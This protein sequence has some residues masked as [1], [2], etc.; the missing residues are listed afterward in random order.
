MGVTAAHLLGIWLIMGYSLHQPG[1]PSAPTPI[2]VEWMTASL[3]TT[4]ISPSQQPNAF[5]KSAAIKPI[6]PSSATNS[7]EQS[8]TA[9]IATEAAA[10]TA[11]EFKLTQPSSA[12]TNSS[13]AEPFDA[14]TPSY[15]SAPAAAGNTD[16]KR[17]PPQLNFNQCPKPIYSW[18]AQRAG[19]QGSVV[20]AFIM[21]TNGSIAEAY[22]EKSSGPTREH[23]QLDRLTLDAVKACQG[24]PG[25][26]DGKPERLS[27]KVEYVWK[28]LD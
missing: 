3:D 21:N 15:N 22:I 13:S 16:A 25:S 4:P 10:H 17:I 18:A 27:G 11:P 5:N 19:T 28:L 1:A 9:T 24:Q 20:I 6:N 12:D 2:Q 26:I 7:A 14:P 23:K 8:T